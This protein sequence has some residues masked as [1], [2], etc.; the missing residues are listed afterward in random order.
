MRA[1]AEFHMVHTWLRRRPEDDAP[2]IKVGR[3]WLVVRD[4]QS[5][6]RITIPYTGRRLYVQNVT[7]PDVARSQ[8]RGRRLC[9]IVDHPLFVPGSSWGEAFVLTA[10]GK[11]GYERSPKGKS[12]AWTFGMCIDRDVPVE[13][14]RLRAPLPSMP[15]KERMT[16]PVDFPIVAMVK[17]HYLLT[18]SPVLPASINTEAD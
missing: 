3:E 13:E 8:V 6:V 16:L 11:T 2:T 1:H 10:R 7:L 15:T 14:I 17:D 18:A 4:D 12:G 5:A 9:E